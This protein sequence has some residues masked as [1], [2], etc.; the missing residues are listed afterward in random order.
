MGTATA[1]REATTEES[2]VTRR[3]TVLVVDDEHGIREALR[4]LLKDDYKVLLANSGRSAIEMLADDK[5]SVDM[6][7]SD[8]KMPELDGIGFLRQAKAMNPQVEIVMVTAY[9]SMDTALAALRHGAFDYIVK[10]F[11]RKEILSAV[12]RGL[13]RRRNFLANCQLVEDLRQSMARN[14]IGTTEA[15]IQTVDAKDSYTRGHSERVAKLLGRLT[16]VLNLPEKQREILTLLARLH[17]IGKIGISEPV[18]RK[19]APLT[20]D[21]WEQMKQHPAI[22]F[23]ILQPVEFLREELPVVLHHHERFDGRGYP[24]GLKGKE[25]PLGARIIAIFDAYDAMVSERSY[26]PRKSPERAVQELRSFAGSQFDPEL[27]EPAIAVIEEGIRNRG[28]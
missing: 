14:Y 19:P 1:M 11:D 18:L 5:D 8:I 4:M 2:A 17:D 20:P 27:V 21:E 26:M 7:F 25:I 6:I 13:D 10:P 15:L 12:E 3:P 16:E 23:H 22:G 28:N 9:P 24:K